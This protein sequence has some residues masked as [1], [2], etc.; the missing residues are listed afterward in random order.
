MKNIKGRDDLL[1]TE[2][3]VGLPVPQTP[4]ELA[5]IRA[6]ALDN[7]VLVGNL[8][9]PDGRATVLT[10]YVNPP[11]GD[12]GFNQRLVAS[13]DALLREVPIPGGAAFQ[14]GVPLTKATYVE[15]LRRHLRV[16]PPLGLAVLVGVLFLCFRTLQ[17]VVIPV[18]T[19]VISVVW[20]LGIMAILGIPMTV[21]TGIIPSLLLAIG[22]TE[23]VHMLTAYHERIR[24]GDGKLTAIR[25]MLEETSLAILVTGATTVLGFASL[26]LTDITMVV[27]FGYASALGLTANLIVTLLAVPLALRL[28]RLPRRAPARGHGRRVR[29]GPPVRLDR[30][31]GAVQ[32]PPARPDPARDGGG[33]GDRTDR[34]G[35]TSG[36]HGSGHVL[37]ARVLGPR[38][39]RRAAAFTAGRSR[40]S[41][42]S[43]IPAARTASRTPR[44]SGASSPSRTSWSAPVEWTGPSPWPTTSAGCTGR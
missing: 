15:Y 29:P 35:S 36:E 7:R 44:Y 21:L 5:R 40:L 31:A 37:P 12:H 25:T 43:S 38:P 2:P 6:D 17:G 26:I 23:D 24:L 16:T 34:R 32:P 10:V 20:T 13:I 3:L 22:F 42:W 4:A 30:A 39:H 41:T 28:W 33:D 1:D 27:E 9:A 11:P 14:V 19:A 8:V 18:L